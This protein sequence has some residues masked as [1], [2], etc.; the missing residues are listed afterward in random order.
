MKR[1]LSSVTALSLMAIASA[2]TEGDWQLRRYLKSLAE[3]DYFAGYDQVRKAN[4]VS[5][6]W[7]Y[8]V[9]KNPPTIRGKPAPKQPILRVWVW[10]NTDKPLRLEPSAFRFVDGGVEVAR[11]NSARSSMHPMGSIVVSPRTLYVG[12]MVM[13]VRTGRR[14][15]DDYALLYT[16]PRPKETIVLNRFMYWKNAMS[17][18]EYQRTTEK[19][20]AFRTV[21]RTDESRLDLSSYRELVTLAD[22][23][24]EQANDIFRR[25]AKRIFEGKGRTM[26]GL[27]ENQVALAGPLAIPPYLRGVGNAQSDETDENGQIVREKAVGTA[28]E[29]KAGYFLGTTHRRGEHP[30]IVRT[31]SGSP[32]EPLCRIE[33]IRSGFD[34]WTAVHTWADVKRFIE[35]HPDGDFEVMGTKQSKERFDF[36]VRV[37]WSAVKESEDSGQPASDPKGVQA[38]PPRIAP[39][40]AEA[41]TAE[42]A[43]D[44]YFVG[45]THRRGDFPPVLR[46]ATPE[47]YLGALYR[48]DGIRLRSQEAFTSVSTWSDVERFLKENPAEEAI[49]QGINDK[50]KAFSSLVKVNKKSLN[51]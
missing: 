37:D 17:E 12:D 6:F 11:N 22:G 38:A 36:K 31:S 7:E 24:D 35:Q 20:Q 2:Q 4:L 16:S 34:G 42:E 43:K 26:A 45:T 14:Y 9:Y 41:G 51:G 48:I 10:N 1:S 50:G 49:V 28:E 40:E 19:Q 30:P 46:T 44:G 13:N 39:T 47:S 21:T 27:W 25:R 8:A 29:A 23:T 33:S 18:D 15:T 5:V 3:K 32:L